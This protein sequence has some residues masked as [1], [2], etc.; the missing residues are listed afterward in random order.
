MIGTYRMTQ[1]CRSCNLKPK[2]CNSKAHA[3]FG[4]SAR[5]TDRQVGKQARS[6][7]AAAGRPGP[8]PETG[9]PNGAASLFFYSPPGTRPGRGAKIPAAEQEAD[10]KLD[11]CKSRDTGDLFWS[12]PSPLLAGRASWYPGRLPRSPGH[13]VRERWATGAETETG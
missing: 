3:L 8:L 1:P 12:F 2:L 10:S 4:L 11:E 9:I 13:C 7:S 6:T 5:G